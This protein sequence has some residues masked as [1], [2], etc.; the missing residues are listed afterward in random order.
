MLNALDHL[1]LQVHE[2]DALSKFG[3]WYSISFHWRTLNSAI[4]S[5]EWKA[6]FKS[7]KTVIFQRQ[8]FFIF[9][10]SS[11]YGRVKIWSM[12]SRLRRDRACCSR[13]LRSQLVVKRCSIV[14]IVGT[15]EAIKGDDLGIIP[16]MKLT[17]WNEGKWRQTCIETRKLSKVERSEVLQASKQ[18]CLVE[19]RVDVRLRAKASDALRSMRFWIVLL[20]VWRI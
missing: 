7:R 17:P 5:T 15:N 19:P 13:V 9:P 4:R 3:K 11:N 10:V 18:M 12:Q 14:K 6:L 20:A 16:V 1:R 2:Y 8:R